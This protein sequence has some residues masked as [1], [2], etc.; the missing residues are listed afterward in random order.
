M[1]GMLALAAL[2]TLADQTSAMM[3]PTTGR[4]MQR[5]PI[6]YPDG[7]NGYAAYHL[8]IGAMDSSGLQSRL[9]AGGF[10]IRTTQGASGL[11]R[12]NLPIFRTG[13][14]GWGK[15]GHIELLK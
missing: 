6:G 9:M 2:L 8:Q 11:Y 13:G 10:H 5:D 15:D 14:H 1:C 4:F 7:M 12:P 3:N